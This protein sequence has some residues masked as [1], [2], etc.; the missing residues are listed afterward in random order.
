M[1]TDVVVI[2][3]GLTGAGVAYHLACAGASVT[4]LERHDLNTQAS[5]CNA[6]SIHAQIPH[7]PF[8]NLGEGWARRFAPAIPLM[9]R[10]IEIWHTLSAELGIDL[11]VVTA[12]GLIVAETDEQMRQIRRKAA[13]ERGQGLAVEILG[14]S[15]LRAE[16][17]YLSDRA[18]G[19]ALCAIEGKANP[20]LAAPAFAR[21]AAEFGARIERHCEVMSVAPDGT[22]GFD[23]LTARGSI[24]ARRVVNCAGAD[25]GRVAAMVGLDLPIEAHP[26]QVTV[27]EPVKPLVKH[28]VYSAAEKL[29]LKQTRAGTLLIGG[30]WP[31]RLDPLSRRPIVDLT[32][33]A[34]NLKVALDAVPALA[35]VQIVRTWA[36]VVN[37]TADWRPIIGEVPRVPGFYLSFFPWM[38]FTAGPFTAKA[39][40]DLV[41]GRKPEIDI[42][43][44]APGAV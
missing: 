44:F 37:G 19:G 22:G 21:K 20:L 29:S 41:L 36:A 28:L 11:D 3:G 34:S 9:T 12:G 35:S 7:E 4:L 23:V 1:R 32:S 26:I 10:S 2:G 5:G 8:A 18:I 42:S 39:T 33:L 40:A 14:R 43:A 16:A 25:A 15:E 27:T 38:G 17:P 30:G 6:G 31:A 24:K 13:I